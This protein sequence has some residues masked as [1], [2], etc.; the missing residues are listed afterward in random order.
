MTKISKPLADGLAFMADA[1]ATLAQTPEDTEGAL[2]LLAMA[3]K[4]ISL[5]F[6]AG[7]TVEEYHEACRSHRDA[8]GREIELRREGAAGSA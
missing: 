3:R 7:G 8:I 1:H 6:K 5:A 4:R 2:A